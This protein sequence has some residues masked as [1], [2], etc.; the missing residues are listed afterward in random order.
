MWLRAMARAKGK[1]LGEGKG[2]GEV[3]RMR[4]RVRRCYTFSQRSCFS[5]CHSARSFSVAIS[6]S[7]WVAKVQ[8]GRA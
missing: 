6:L 4:I 1:K 8:L 2:G 7:A 3:V 5:S